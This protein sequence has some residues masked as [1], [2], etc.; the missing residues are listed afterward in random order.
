M[1]R[2]RRT[3]STN[4]KSR[5]AAQTAARWPIAQTASPTSQKPQAEAQR[6]RQRAVENG[7]AAR[8][9][10]EQDVLGQRP[11]D[12]H[13]IARHFAGIVG[14]I[15]HQTSAPPLNEKNDRKKLDAAN[16]IE[17]PKTIWI[18]RRKP[19]DVSPKASARPVE[20]MTITAIILA[21]GPSID[22]R[23]D[24]SGASHGID[25]PDAVD[26]GRTYCFSGYADAICEVLEKK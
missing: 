1:R 5:F 25:E 22:W 23:M 4:I 12:R 26:P 14:R 20:M 6:R 21:T 8:R 19:P 17:R 9:A 24:C 10:A 13:G 16:A 2:W 15:C 7:E 11:V 3:T 18:S